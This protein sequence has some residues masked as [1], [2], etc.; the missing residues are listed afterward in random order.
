MLLY[1]VVAF[2]LPPRVGLRQLLDG[3]TCQAGRTKERGP[4]DSRRTNRQA[5]HEPR[6]PAGHP[7]KERIQLA[8]ITNLSIEISS[9]RPRQ[10]S[11]KVG[12]GVSTTAGGFF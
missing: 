10:Y 8:Q 5:K 12:P 1:V 4:V 11:R 2:G 3:M 7:R 9:R 6:G